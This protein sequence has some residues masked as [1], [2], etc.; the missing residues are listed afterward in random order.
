MFICG[1]TG[2]LLKAELI[3][4][5]PN[6]YVCNVFNKEGEFLY[7]TAEPK[8]LRTHKENES[9][10]NSCPIHIT[11]EEKKSDLQCRKK[12]LTPEEIDLINTMYHKDN[13]TRR[14]IADTLN[15]SYVSVTNVISG[16]TYTEYKE[17]TR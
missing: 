5:Y 11:E 12:K 8:Q 9:I 6:F 1:E 14:E 4:E 7:R 13:M 2:L 3:E 17:M 15:K 10:L 16:A